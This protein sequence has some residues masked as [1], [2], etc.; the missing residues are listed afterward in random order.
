MKKGVYPERVRWLKSNVK[1]ARDLRRFKEIF[2]NAKI[3]QLT[4]DMELADCP[5][6]F[7]KP[8]VIIK[9]AKV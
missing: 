2:K 8:K 4:T 5:D 3:C 1:N 7:G 6:F 9:R